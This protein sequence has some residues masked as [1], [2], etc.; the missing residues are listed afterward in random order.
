MLAVMRREWSQDAREA[1][2]NRRADRRKQQKRDDPYS[3]REASL[4][5]ERDKVRDNLRELTTKTYA[6]EVGR[7]PCS[8]HKHGEF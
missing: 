2:I 4:E 1:W 7:S 8:T 6:W 3:L 5:R